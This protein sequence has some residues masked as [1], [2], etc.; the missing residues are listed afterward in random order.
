MPRA[1]HITATGDA[2]TMAMHRNARAG[3]FVSS[4]TQCADVTRHR[5]SLA[6]V[7]A[8]RRPC[9]WPLLR[10]LRWSHTSACESWARALSLCRQAPSLCSHGSH[11]RGI[12]AR[13]GRA[14]S[15]CTGG[16]STHAGTRFV[17]TAS[18]KRAQQRE[19]GGAP[20]NVRGRHGLTSGPRPAGM[21]TSAE[22]PAARAGHP[23]GRSETPPLGLAFTPH[24]GTPPEG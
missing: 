4:C 24:R 14:V 6:H 21:R 18:A 1:R 5:A 11:Q 9:R 7:R 17:V 15:R 2:S 22:R 23:P 10:H 13:A 8:P 3:C 12:A 16:A 20:P 19:P